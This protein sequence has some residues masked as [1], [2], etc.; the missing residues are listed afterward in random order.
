[1]TR[2]VNVEREVTYVA[3]ILPAFILY[4]IFFIIPVVMGLYYSFTNWTGISKNV[5]FVGLSNYQKLFTD[6][7]FHQAL[8]FN[9]KYTVLLVVLTVIISMV[10]AYCL[11]RHIRGR[12]FFRGSM[13][14][15]AVLSMLTVGM[16]FN[17]IF[18][19]MLPAIGKVLNITFVQSNI[20]SNP[21]TA[22]YGI[23]FV[24]LWQG[25]AIPTVLLLAGLQTIPGEMYEASELDGASKWQQY[26]KITLP[27]LIPVLSVVLI[28]TLKSGLVVFD[29]IVALTEGGPAGQTKSLAFN[30]YN[31]G[32]K[33][34]KFSYAISQAMVVT[35]IVVVISYIQLRLTSRKKVY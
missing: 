12:T 9:A 13:F 1:M 34:L 16:I 27:F 21:I 8:I 23:L 18:T 24:H 25:V 6:R 10:L 26:W 19:R 5:S 3:F 32:F 11:N 2:K 20:L 29:Y 17:E 14:F 4:A 15:P 35:A 31:L 33:E 28:L 30:I 22:I 7:V